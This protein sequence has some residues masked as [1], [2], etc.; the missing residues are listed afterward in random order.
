MNQTINMQGS[1]SPEP[2]RFLFPLGSFLAVLGV[3]PWILFFRDRKIFERE[4]PEWHIQQIRPMMPFV[5]LLS[6]GVSMRS[7]T[8]GWTWFLWRSLEKLVPSEKAG[9]FAHVTLLRRDPPARS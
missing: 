1:F 5:Y 3:L 2:Y 6:G 4:F 9:M 8:P 7:L